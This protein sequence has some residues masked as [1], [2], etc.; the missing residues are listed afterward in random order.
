ML[1]A[2][3]FNTLL[4]SQE[5][6]A[7][8]IGRLRPVVG[9]GVRGIPF[10]VTI[11]ADPPDSCQPDPFRAIHPDR[12]H[13]VS[14]ATLQPYSNIRSVSNR[15]DTP[16]MSEFEKRGR[17]T[18]PCIKNISSLSGRPEPFAGND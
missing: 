2:L 15:A 14:G 7:F 9:P 12:D 11:L 1:H 4:S 8:T 18:S 6:D 10:R 13:P 17:R 5:T 16:E 3:A